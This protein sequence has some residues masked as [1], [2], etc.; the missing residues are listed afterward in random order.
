[1]T[2]RLILDI[3]IGT[4]IISSLAI[5][6][7]VLISK[8]ITGPILTFIQKIK[9]IA[10]KRDL[11]A[12]FSPTGQVEFINLG[13]A[14]NDLMQQLEE[15]MA[16]M[17]HT[18][19]ELTAKSMQLK[20]AT[21]TTVTQVYQ[22]NEEVNSAATATTE[23]S[24]SVAE[25]ATHAEHAA[26]SMRDTRIKVQASHHMSD[27]ARTTIRALRTNMQHSIENMTLLEP[28]EHWNRSGI[29]CDPNDSGT[30]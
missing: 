10:E 28:R 9:E 19:N 7:G 2:N 15:F 5:V 6:I 13:H 20:D 14:M 3:A 4:L 12:R 30:D 29:R 25:V 17:Q 8:R 26:N 11:S 22:Q 23:V 24:A 21:Q 1:M 27:N 16:D 18:S